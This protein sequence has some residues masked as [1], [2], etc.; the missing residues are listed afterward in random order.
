MS[1]YDNLLH[2]LITKL[3]PSLATKAT[4]VLI[5]EAATR[6]IGVGRPIESATLKTLGIVVFNN[7]D[8]F[9]RAD[10]VLL[11]AI[12]QKARAAQLVERTTQQQ[13]RR[14]LRRR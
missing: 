10:L 11:N 4:E 7:S 13:I 9:A 8:A 3:R 2:Q 14:K 5:K 1:D 6:L 12:I